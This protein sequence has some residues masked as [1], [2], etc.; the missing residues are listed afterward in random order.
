MANDFP[1]EFYQAP[2]KTIFIVERIDISFEEQVIA[3][4]VHIYHFLKNKA[5]EKKV[6]SNYLG[7]LGLLSS[8]KESMNDEDNESHDRSKD[9]DNS[10]MDGINSFVNSS[11]NSS[12][13][14]L[15]NNNE[16]KNKKVFDVK[17][18]LK[19]ELDLLLKV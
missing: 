12:D 16:A 5:W 13:D 19:T 4:I 1:L 14:E 3:F 11:R 9:Y 8:I 10:M 6:S 17:L 15:G 7:K 2:E 18:Y